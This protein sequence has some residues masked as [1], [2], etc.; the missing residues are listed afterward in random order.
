MYSVDLY[1]RVRSACHFG[2]TQKEALHFIKQN[3]HRR[4]CGSAD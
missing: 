1:S 4:G 3:P 2:P